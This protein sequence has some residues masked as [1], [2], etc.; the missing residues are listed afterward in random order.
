MRLTG[1]LMADEREEFGF[2]PQMMCGQCRE[3][4]LDMIYRH[5]IYTEEQIFAGKHDE[6]GCGKIHG[7]VMPGTVWGEDVT[8]ICPCCSFAHCTHR[9]KA[10]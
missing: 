10:A 8:C 2:L 4:P 5:D 1:H 3:H 9:K 7:T 6:C